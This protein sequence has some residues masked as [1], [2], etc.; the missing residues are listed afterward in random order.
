MAEDDRAP[1]TSA[2]GVGDAFVDADAIRRAL[3]RLKA[4]DRTYLALHYAEDRSVA[5]IAAMVGAP[6]GTVKWRLSRARQSLERL[7]AK[8]HR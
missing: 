4:D 8:E 6:D 7:L 2:G 1:G 5:E 3:D